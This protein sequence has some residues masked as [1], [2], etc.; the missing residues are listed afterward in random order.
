MARPHQSRGCH[1]D[2]VQFSPAARK[3][4]VPIVVENDEDFFGLRRDWAKLEQARA[5]SVLLRPT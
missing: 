2:A 1:L 4:A 5:V 3:G